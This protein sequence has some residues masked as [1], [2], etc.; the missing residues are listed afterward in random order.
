MSSAD[1]VVGEKVQVHA[2]GTWYQGEVE[3]VMPKRL[4]I[5]YVTNGG[6]Q[7]RKVVNPEKVESIRTRGL[8][9]AHTRE[10]LVR[11]VPA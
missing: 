4:S 7:R 8:T 10:P 6:N 5:V 11:K 9:Y 1:F 2:S 3:R